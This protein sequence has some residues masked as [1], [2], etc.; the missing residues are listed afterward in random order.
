MTREEAIKLLVNAIYS[1]E[2]QGN[3]DLTTAR[4]MAIKA[5]EKETKTG[6]WIELFSLYSILE[7]LSYIQGKK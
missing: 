6:Q 2:G 7:V 5:P 4:N 1:N 3:E